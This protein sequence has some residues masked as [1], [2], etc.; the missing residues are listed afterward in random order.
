MKAVV[1]DAHW[2]FTTLYVHYND[3]NGNV[4]TYIKGLEYDLLKVVLE[5]MNM[6]FVHVPTPEGFEK[7]DATVNDLLIDMLAKESY[8]ALGSLVATDNIDLLFDYTYTYYTMIIRWYVPCSDKYPRWSSIFRILSLEL[9]I[10]LIISIV[11]AAIS[12]TLVGRYS[13]TS[14]CHGYK[15][16]TSSLTNIWA[17][18]LGVPV[19]T[20]PRTPSLRSLFFAWVCFSLAFSTV[21]QAFL[22][23]FL[24][25][26]G[27]KIPIQYMDELFAS[28]IKL[29]Y[30][31]GNKVVGDETEVSNV[32]RNRVYCPTYWDCLNWAKYQKNVSIVVSDMMAEENYATGGFVGGNSEPLLCRIDDGVVANTGLTMIMFHGDPLLKRVNEII[33]RVV[34]AGLYN[35]WFSLRINNLKLLSRKIRI[36]HPL[37]EYY[38]FNL[39]HMQP[40]FYLLL[41]GWCL[42]VVCFF[43]EVLYVLVLRKRA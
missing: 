40:G 10:V 36:V 27:Y 19:S 39:Y 20:L 43:V 4:G 26:S 34:E 21:F 31:Q 38:S 1:R 3:S 7:Q 17:V 25:D 24:I 33:H 30:P 11:I 6:T 28:G 15:T 9:W 2:D 22:T 18:I 13:C 29:A 32:E 42:S 35:C 37:D 14:Y 23:T 12:I 5:Q 8:I 16:L 41:M